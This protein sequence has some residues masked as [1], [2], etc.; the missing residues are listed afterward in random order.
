MH[1]DQRKRWRFSLRYPESSTKRAAILKINVENVKN[2]EVVYSLTLSKVKDKVESLCRGHAIY[3]V[4][5]EGCLIQ[6]TRL[7][8][9]TLTV[10]VVGDLQSWIHFRMTVNGPA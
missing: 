2:P 7:S 9:S 1:R 6:D 3:E 8:A 5:K 10:P 4:S